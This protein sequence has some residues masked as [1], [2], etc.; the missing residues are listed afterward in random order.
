MTTPKYK[1]FR[2]PTDLTPNR[3]ACSLFVC[4][5]EDGNYFFLASSILWCL[6]Y[7]KPNVELPNLVPSEEQIKDSSSYGH[8]ILLSEST[9]QRLMTEKAAQNPA[10]EALKNWINSYLENC[11]G[12]NPGDNC[13]C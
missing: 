12:N 7:D 10:Y 5:D 11:K 3:T 1:T 6:G 4:V 2:I 8:A 9:V 13:P